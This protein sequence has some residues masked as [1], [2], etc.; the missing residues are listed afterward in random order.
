MACSR[1]NFTFILL[2]DEKVLL[3]SLNTA[4]TSVV[5]YLQ[6][7]AVGHGYVRCNVMVPHVKIYSQPLKVKI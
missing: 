1:V 5:P 7:Q 2:L 6:L 4:T 3:P